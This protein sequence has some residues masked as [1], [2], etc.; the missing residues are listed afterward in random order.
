MINRKPAVAGQFYSSNPD[1]LKQEL[2]SL[3]AKAKHPKFKNI[4]AVISPHAGYV[5]SGKVAASSFNQLDI[6]VKYKDIV[7]IGTS[8]HLNLNGASIDNRGSHDTP[9]GEVKVNL[10]IAN[11]LI[12]NYSVFE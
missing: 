7:M 10:E 4:R 9:F 2:D 5:F 12:D 6:S 8:H 11:K 3:F 1:T